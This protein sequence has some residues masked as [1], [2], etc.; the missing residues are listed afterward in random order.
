VQTASAA[1][2]IERSLMGWLRARGIDL[3]IPIASG[4]TL[5]LS[6]YA[7]AGNVVLLYDAYDA[8]DVKATEPNGSQSK[9]RTYINY[10]TNAGAIT[11]SPATL[12]TS[13]MWTGGDPWPIGG[14][15]LPGGVKM[16]L[17]GILGAPA[18][19]GNASANKGCTTHLRLWHESDVLWDAA[20]QAGIPFL[21]LIGQVADACVYTPVASL[22]GP[23]T[24]ELPKP[25]YM[26]EPR[27]F[28]MPAALTLQVILS[29]AASG[30]L[31]A[32]QL[33][34]AFIL[35]RELA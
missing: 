20:D 22:V 33:D 17:L 10:G 30:G 2:H 1:E 31:A 19:R 8:A 4:E 13:H 26:P 25:P 24:A 15:P 6:R 5:T 23:L 9:T 32:A 29:N 12:D 7:E 14:A 3:S 34:V 28:T 18:S 16:T 21:G 27:V 11:A 35:K